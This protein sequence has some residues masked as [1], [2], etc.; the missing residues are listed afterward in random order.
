MILPETGR[1]AFNGK[2]AIAIH[3]PQC[4]ATIETAFYH[5]TRFTIGPNDERQRHQ[6]THSKNRNLDGN[7][8]KYP[9]WIII[10]AFTGYSVS[11]KLFPIYLEIR[12][13]DPIIA[14]FAVC[15]SYSC[16]SRYSFPER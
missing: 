2:A 6:R 8:P 14:T 10:F 5:I 16:L 7:T 15:N 1:D 9:F 11:G 13:Y 4:W 12:T 3:F